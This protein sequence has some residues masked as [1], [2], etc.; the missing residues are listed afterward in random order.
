MNQFDGLSALISEN[1]Q[2]IVL[3][4]NVQGQSELGFVGDLLYGSLY[5]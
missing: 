1:L 3:P 4:F 5:N 2:C